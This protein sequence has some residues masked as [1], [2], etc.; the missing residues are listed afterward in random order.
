MIDH[1]ENV[2][3]NSTDPVMKAACKDAA[4]KALKYYR[5]N[6]LSNN[7]LFA[8]MLDPRIKT[9]WLDYAYEL[10]Y[11][12]A[13]K[14]MLHNEMVKI[15]VLVD[16]KIDSIVIQSGTECKNDMSVAVV[17]LPEW[18]VEAHHNHHHQYSSEDPLEQKLKSYL[19]EPTILNTVKCFDVL[20][21]WKINAAKYPHL[22]EL[23]RVYLAIPAGSV[24]VERWFSAGRDLLGIHHASLAPETIRMCMLL[25]V[26]LKA[27]PESIQRE[28]MLEFSQR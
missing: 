4:E 12:K 3:D 16:E 21:W 28:V 15:K 9:D 10:D 18:Q 24:S 17:D 2:G 20:N 23:A 19:K 7:C 27:L 22:A 13:S 1:F 5:K 26:W 14:E 6:S 8:M 25:R 11:V